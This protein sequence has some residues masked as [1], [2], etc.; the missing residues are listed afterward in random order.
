MTVKKLSELHDLVIND[1][2]DKI[3]SGEAK[4]AD[5]NVAR[6]LLKDNNIE[7]IPADNSP[8]QNLIDEL[9]FNDREETV[10]LNKFKDFRNF[11]FYI[12]RHLRLPNPT[13]AQ[14]EIAD[15]LQSDEKR[16]V[17]QG[18]SGIG[19][20]YVTSAFV[21]HQLFLDPQKNILVVSAS[22]NRADDFSTFCLRLLNEVDILHHL[23]PTEDQRQS[24]ISFDV[25][26][27][28]ASTCS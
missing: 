25:R 15:Y 22:K 24:K 4:A 23:I 13:D 9:P 16:L 6:Q 3:R 26:P 18:F 10:S 19:K 21:L 8:L 2:I 11:L 1:L 7:A 20:S 12:W 17:I 28:K 14:Y 5:L 27:A